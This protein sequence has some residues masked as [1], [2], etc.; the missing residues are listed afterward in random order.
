[1]RLV[2]VQTMMQNIKVNNG[3]QAK[4]APHG[5]FQGPCQL[6]INI[7]TPACSQVGRVTLSKCVFK[8]QTAA[9]LRYPYFNTALTIQ[10]EQRNS[11]QSSC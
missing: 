11:K 3:T 8:T 9:T 7:I 4:L 10:E 2:P 5:K 6:G 1:M